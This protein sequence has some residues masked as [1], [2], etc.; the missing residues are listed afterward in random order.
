MPTR[1]EI[2]SAA[3]AATVI[4][5]ASRPVSAANH[6]GAGAPDLSGKAILITGTSSGFGHLGALH[7]A[8]AGAKVIAT[9]RNLPRPEADA[10]VKA[11]KDEGLDLHVVELDVLDPDSVIG[12]VAKAER[13]AGG[14]LDVIVNN[15]G[16]SFGLPVELQDEEAAR[17]MFDTN[18]LGYQR[19]ARAALPGMRD[20]KRGQVFN[21]SSQL[22]R[23]VIPG[24]GLYSATKF[25]VEAQAEQ[26]A[27]ELAP[28][29]IDVTIIQPGGYPTAIWENASANTQTL[30][31]RLS[32][33]EKTAYQ[34]FIDNATRVG[35]GGDSDPMDIPRAIAEIIAMPAGQRPLRRAVHPVT[36]PQEK[37]NEVSAATQLAIL[38]D[39]PYGPMVKAVLG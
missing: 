36:R 14:A 13:L 8:R 38:G 26:M 7:Y 15:A 27:Y 5:A 22:G 1:R 19:V 10:L 29:G 21:V 20:V 11:A 17:L 3:S 2:L 32:D 35:T 33:D 28:H 4:A 30:I 39:S 31:D 18:V 37:I 16:I 12:G 24:F 9:M 23:V 6:Q 34:G 25:A